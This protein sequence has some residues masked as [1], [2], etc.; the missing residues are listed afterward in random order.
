MGWLSSTAVAPELDLAQLILRQPG[1]LVAVIGGFLVLGLLFWGLAG[2]LHWYRLPAA[3]AGGGL[4]L[5]LAVTLVRSG[6]HLPQAV[7]DPLALCVRDSFSL[8]GGLPVL[9]F[10]MLMPFAF[11]G[12]LAN[13]RPISVTVC[14]ALLS[15][16]IEV[17]QAYTG[18]GICQKQDFLNN[19]A[20]ALLAALIAWVVVAILGIE[21]P[22]RL[23]EHEA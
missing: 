15:A 17:T 10:A 21:R 13:R 8:H 4:A 22:S 14:C 11:F 9:N 12:T 23:R 6:G 19:T 18:L 2:A 16:G 5:A 1:V 7:G 20:G 3:L